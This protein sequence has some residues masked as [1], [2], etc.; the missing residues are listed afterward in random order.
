MD[1]DKLRDIKK[2]ALI[3]AFVI[4][5][6]IYEHYKGQKYL[7]LGLAQPLKRPPGGNWLDLGEATHSETGETKYV[8][9]SGGHNVNFAPSMFVCPADRALW[10]RSGELIDFE[11]GDELVVYVPLYY[12]GQE[13][14]L[15]VRPQGMWSQLVEIETAYGKSK[16]PRFRL[17][18]EGG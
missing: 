11:E 9:I 6:A 3:R 5:G 14:G 4:P 15:F 12:T 7:A 10:G 2:H 16:T 13:H 17:V 18:N 8:G 1:R